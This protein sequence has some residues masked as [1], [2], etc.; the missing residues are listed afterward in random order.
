VDSYTATGWLLLLNKTS[1][2]FS[3]AC[4]TGILPV[5]SSAVYYYFRS[6]LSNGY[7]Q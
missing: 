5:T 1:E 4:G 7:S 6:W 2:F 3:S